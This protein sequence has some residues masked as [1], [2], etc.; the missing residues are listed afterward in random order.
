MRQWFYSIHNACISV[1]FSFFIPPLSFLGALASQLSI[2]NYQF[3][4]IID[5]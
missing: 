5:H 3:S 2:F 4:I 1:V